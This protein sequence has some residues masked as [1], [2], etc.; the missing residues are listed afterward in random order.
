V[1]VVGGVTYYAVTPNMCSQIWFVP[2]VFSKGIWQVFVAFSSK[3][4]ALL[5]N[6]L[7][8]VWCLDKLFSWKYLPR[9]VSRNCHAYESG[10]STHDFRNATTCLKL[11]D[12]QN[13]IDV[14]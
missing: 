13:V 3:T 8:M 11:V 2:T 5:W 9:H 14:I 4:S 1:G 6:I 10:F 12:S 7:V